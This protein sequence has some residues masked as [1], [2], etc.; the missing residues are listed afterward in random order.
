MNNKLPFFILF[1]LLIYYK[2]SHAQ[3]NLL[4][5]KVPQEVGKL[6]KE[7]AILNHETPQEYGYVSDRDILWSKTIWEII[8]LN[9]R[10]NISL[11]YPLDTLNLGTDRRSLFDILRKN[12]KNGKITEVYNSPYFLEK[13]SY[14]EILQALQAID[15]LDAGYDQLNA[16]EIID[17][18]YIQTRNITSAEITQYRIKGT[19]Y[20]DKRLGEMRYRLLGIAP[21]A[22]DVYSLN[23]SPEDQDLVELFWVWYPGVREIFANNTAFNINNSA[24]PINFDYLLNSR[25][26][27]AIIYKEENAYEDR[28]IRDYIRDNAL[29]QLLESDRVKNQIRAFESS[30]W[31]Y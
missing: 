10:I 15:T 13:I 18:Q 16:G 14:N 24:K 8:D 19:W 12:I 30:M 22:P 26:F 21:V 4:N 11:A 23:E 7:E 31:Q 17:P 20:F 2:N 3:A 28:E 29:L 9:N 27:N 1:I 25:S 6:S 5:A